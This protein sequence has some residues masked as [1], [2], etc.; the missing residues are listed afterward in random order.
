MKLKGGSLL[1]RYRKE[2]GMTQE[3]LAEA[4]GVT[5]RTIQRIESGV[6]TPQGQ[7][8][9]LLA[10]ALQIR[11]V[12]LVPA[13]ATSSSSEPVLLPL[14]HILPLLGLALPFVNI[15]LL[16][17]LW[18][19]KRDEHPEYNRQGRE[20]INFQITITLVIVLSFMIMVLYF[21]VGFPLMIACY[22]AAAIFCILNTIR[23]LK[24]IPAHYPLY[25]HF[26]K[27]A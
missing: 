2:K 1:A 19:M 21:P 10:D 5:A 22:V 3:Q 12:D 24:G 7:T 23:A 9:K 25:V 16:L 6:V 8:L 11:T 17:V 20:A 26:L 15:I 4:S 14:Y 18:T 27:K 13:N